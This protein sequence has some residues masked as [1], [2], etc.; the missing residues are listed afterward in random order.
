MTTVFCDDSASPRMHA[1]IAGVGAYTYLKDGDQPRSD[2]PGRILGQLTSP[3]RSAEAVGRW[4]LGNQTM[5]PVKPLGSLEMVIS[6]SLRLVTGH[7]GGTAADVEVE[8]A[9][10]E[11]F[12]DSLGRWYGRCH[13]N[14][15]NVA[16]FY[17]SGHGIQTDTLALLLEDVGKDRLRFFEQAF[18]FD[19][20]YDGMAWCDAGVQCY[21]VDAC[22][23]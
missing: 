21:F 12:K 19:G 18:D 14:E 22:R 17:F 20:L 3:P 10:L 11:H 9:T 2:W 15:G 23:T 13:A 8:T 1:L 7:A 4:L 5:D 6:P 16:F